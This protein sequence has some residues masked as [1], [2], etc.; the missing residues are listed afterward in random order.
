MTEKIWHFILDKHPVLKQI[1][2]MYDLDFAH[3]QP[4]FTFTIGAKVTIDT[5]SRA[6]QF[7]TT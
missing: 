6:I 3:T 7:K 5:I 4:L 1:P 2:V